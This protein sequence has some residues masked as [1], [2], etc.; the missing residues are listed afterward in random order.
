MTIL[1]NLLVLSLCLAL[2]CTGFLVFLLRLFTRFLFLPRSYIF[3]SLSLLFF[4]F[5]VEDWSE[6]LDVLCPVSEVLVG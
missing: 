3:S 5:C 4:K 6:E 2:F 1:A